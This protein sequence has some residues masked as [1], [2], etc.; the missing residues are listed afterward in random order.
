MLEIVPI[1][2]VIV[3]VGVGV[4]FEDVVI[5]NSTPTIHGNIVG[6]GVGVGSIIVNPKSTSSHGTGSGGGV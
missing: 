1:V 4:G 6:V 5:V 3:G 2:G